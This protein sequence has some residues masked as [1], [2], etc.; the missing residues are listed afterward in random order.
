MTAT[1]REQTVR[2]VTDKDREVQG[3]GGSE[4]KRLADRQQ[5]EGKEMNTR[6]GRGVGGGGRH[7]CRRETEAEEKG[8]VS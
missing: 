6:R 8:G 1:E 7:A 4:M 2:A 3:K 5:T